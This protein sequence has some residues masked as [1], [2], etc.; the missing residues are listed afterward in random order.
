MHIIIQSLLGSLLWLASLETEVRVNRAPGRPSSFPVTF[1]AWAHR[2]RPRLKAGDKIG[3]AP[4]TGACERGVAKAKWLF[5][6]QLLRPVG[7][8]WREHGC[9]R[10]QGKA[11]CRLGGAGV[12]EPG[13]S[14]VR[15]R[16][17]RVCNDEGM[18]MAS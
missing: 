4:L 10:G 18:D 2:W 13:K 8:Q 7:R 12:E 1:Y 5:Q 9:G 14:L 6:E 17:S 11:L 15:S 16:R 3:E